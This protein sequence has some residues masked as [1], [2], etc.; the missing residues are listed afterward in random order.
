MNLSLSIRSIA[1]FSSSTKTIAPRKGPI[2]F[3][4]PPTTAITRISM[5]MSTPI[6]PGEIRP[7]NQTSRTPADPAITP[8]R[9]YAIT[10]CQPT[11]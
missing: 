11:W 2:G 4:N 8:E 1:K 10:L 6:D 9:K 3:L 7:L 5:T